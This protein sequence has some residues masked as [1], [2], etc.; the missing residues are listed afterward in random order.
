MRELETV[1]TQPKCA[2]GSGS[3]PGCDG[4]E[5]IGD[6]KTGVNIPASKRQPKG[7]LI[8]WLSSRVKCEPCGDEEALRSKVLTC[9]SLTRR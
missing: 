9:V 3:A 5:N 7:A 2:Y 8:S 6:S 4:I 1:R